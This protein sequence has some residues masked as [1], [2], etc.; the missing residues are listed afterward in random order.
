MK[1]FSYWNEFTQTRNAIPMSTYFMS[2]YLFFSYLAISDLRKYWCI[3]NR[4]LRSIG[5]RRRTFNLVTIIYLEGVQS[6]DHFQFT[7]GYLFHWH[8]R[9]C[10][11]RNLRWS[12][13]KWESSEETIRALFRKNKF[14]VKLKTK[15]N[16]SKFAMF[17]LT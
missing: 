6:P 13:R 1:I 11:S 3:E 9:D 17:M 12:L 5:S 10:Q 16:A 14:L 2:M 15:R 8:K 7:N 4:S